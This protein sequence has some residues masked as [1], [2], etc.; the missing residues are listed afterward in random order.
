[1][2]V[3]EMYCIKNG[4]ELIISPSPQKRKITIPKLMASS[5]GQKQKPITV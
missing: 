2:K 1:M 4:E 5:G 3:N